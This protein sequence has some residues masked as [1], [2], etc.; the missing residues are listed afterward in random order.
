MVSALNFEHHVQRLW[1]GGVEDN[2]SSHIGLKPPSAKPRAHLIDLEE[3]SGRYGRN[4]LW[5]LLSES[6]CL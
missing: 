6:P 3:I 4:T 5:T 1:G 2:R